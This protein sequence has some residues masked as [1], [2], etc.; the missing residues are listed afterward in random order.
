MDQMKLRFTQHARDKFLILE[1]HNFTVAEETVIEA[2]RN[3]EKIE[4]SRNNRFVA[5]RAVDKEHLIADMKIKYDRDADILTLEFSE[6]G[7][8]HAE[9]AGPMIIHLSE[10]NKPVLVEIL[11]A[12]QFLAD[13]T[14]ISIKTS[15]GDAVEAKT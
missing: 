1:R 11:D 8:D 12:S 7:I 4:R 10:D 13:M 5:E 15:A 6:S 3:P 2:V 14:R 9:E